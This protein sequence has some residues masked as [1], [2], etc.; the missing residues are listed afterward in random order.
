MVNGMTAGGKM[1]RDA[2]LDWDGAAERLGV[3]PRMVK[4]LW[5]KRQLAGI[6]VG[7]HVRFDVADVD[8][9]ID[10]HRVEVVR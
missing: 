9:Y 1:T 10:D 8:R 2:L 3:T 5:A 6:R 7:K 4:E